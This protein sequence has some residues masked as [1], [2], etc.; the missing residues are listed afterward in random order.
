MEAFD[1][2]PAGDAETAL[3][4]IE[5]AFAVTITVRDLT[6]WLAAPDGRRLVP[7]ERNGHRRQQVCDLGFAAA[8]VDHCRHGIGAALRGGAGICRHRCWKGVREVVVP[9]VRGATLHGYLFAGAWRDDGP[10]PD[11]PWSMARRRLPLWSEERGAAVA[12]A[13]GL[14]A[15]GLWSAAEQ[16]RTAGPLPAA[17]LAGRVRA[18]VRAHLSQPLCRDALA[19]H[20]GLSASRTSHAVRQACGCSIQELMARERL[21]VAQRLLAGDDRPVAEIGALV[22]WGD[23]PHF[24]RI[25]RRLTGLPPATWRTRLRVH[26]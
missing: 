7:W 6:G 12:S 26:A 10:A 15:A 18:W 19:R 11:G 3:A 1:P 23:P 9:V 4:A 22:G 13:L 16:S 21:A 20:L 17:D 24:T 14:I 5:T 2:W 25:F 8:C